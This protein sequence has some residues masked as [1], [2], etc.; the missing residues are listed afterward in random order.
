MV[1]LKQT[2]GN[3]ARKKELESDT[4]HLIVAGGREDLGGATGFFSAS[5]GRRHG[6]SVRRGPADQEYHRVGEH[7]AHV[8]QDAPSRRRRGK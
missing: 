8:R 4:L 5:D 1:S 2:T 3:T 7:G 6:Q